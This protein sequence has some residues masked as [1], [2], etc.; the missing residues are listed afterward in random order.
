MKAFLRCMPAAIWAAFAVCLV[1]CHP[2]ES[3]PGT[4][5]FSVTEIQAYEQQAARGESEAEFML[6]LV[7]QQGL[8]KPVDPQKAV[9]WF[10]R[11]GNRGH[12]RA[13]VALGVML[14][15]GDGVPADPPKAAEWFLKAAQLDSREAQ[16][17]LAEMSRDGQG[18]PKD[19]V[20]A[21]M[22][23]QLADHGARHI[24]EASIAANALKPS[25][26]RDQVDEATRRAAAFRPATNEPAPR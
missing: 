8:G 2:G 9:E 5:A 25:M 12:A 19:P 24:K 10:T 14:R 1:G 13:Q 3:A 22:W 6:G 11:A 23:F 21:L 15:S 20:Q 18:V 7:S 4:P 17:Y 16:F 26:T